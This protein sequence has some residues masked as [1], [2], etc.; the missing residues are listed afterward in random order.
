[1]TA[2][3]SGPRAVAAAFVSF[4]RQHLSDEEGAAVLLACAESKGVG[5]SLPERELVWDGLQEFVYRYLREKDIARYRAAIEERTAEGK[6]AVDPERVSE[7]RLVDR[8]SSRKVARTGAGEARLP[9]DAEEALEQERELASSLFRREHEANRHTAR[10]QKLRAEALAAA[11]NRCV[12][13][14][15]PRRLELH[16]KHYD[17]L[18]VESLRD[19]VILCHRCHQA[20]TDRQRGLRRARWRPWRSGRVTLWR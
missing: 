2:E 12:R 10:Y 6:P 20:E 13:C 15:S 7:I 4:C 16:H 8:R 18:G 14:G 11:D 3:M 17:T 19:V 5:W 9:R 1:M